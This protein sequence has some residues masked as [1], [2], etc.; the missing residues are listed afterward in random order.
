MKLSV[1][2]FAL[3]MIVGAVLMGDRNLTRTFFDNISMP[4]SVFF[5][6]SVKATDLRETFDTVSSEKKKLRVLIV[7]GHE[8]DFGGAEYLNIKERDL[9]A[10]L[11]L[12]LAQYLVEDG[13]FEVSMTRGKDGWNPDLQN[14]FTMNGEDIKAFARAKKEEMAR[15]IGEGKIMRVSDAVPHNDAPS[16]VASRLYGINKW[17][18]DRKADIII[19]IHFNDNTPRRINVPG[20]HNGFAIY[21]PERQYSN[22]QA[23]NEIAQYVFERLSRMFPISS[24]PAE[25]KG[26][27]EEQD[28]IALG[29]YNSVDGAS[30]LIEYG[31]IYE[32]QF[33]VSSVRDMMIKE[34]AFQTY[35]GLAD[36]FGETSPLVG[37]YESTILPYEGISV[38]ENNASANREVLAFQAA[39]MDKG[40]YPPQDS[41]KNICPLSGV[42]GPCTRAALAT[43]QREFDIKGEVGAIGAKTRVKLRALFQPNLTGA[44]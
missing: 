1:A 4:A 9:N 5:T 10:D 23:A 27:V 30:I 11:A 17:A 41:T 8:P 14:Y 35:L 24:L 3:M 13:H 12:A 32:P 19:H 39:L 37:P 28:L 20:E 42:F 22:S 21:T 34:L 36:F 15:L 29:S 18:N 25:D 6:Q 2:I 40:F 44:L 16:D 31:Y 7:P 43:F 33:K 26:I 38:V